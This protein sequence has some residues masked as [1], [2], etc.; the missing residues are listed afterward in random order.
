[1]CQPYFKNKSNYFIFN[2]KNLKKPLIYFKKCNIKRIIVIHTN[3]AI[4]SPAKHAIVNHAIVNHAQHAIVSHAQ[5]TIVSPAKHA[6]V[7]PAKHAIVSPTRTWLYFAE[8]VW[9]W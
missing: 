8:I 6:I 9:V 2:S 3:K 1:M 5:H 7:S 4:V